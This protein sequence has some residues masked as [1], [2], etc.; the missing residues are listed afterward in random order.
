MTEREE[1]VVKRNMDFLN[2]FSPESGQRVLEYLSKVLYEKIPTY[3]DNNP[4]GTAF[5]EG[6]RFA[7]LEIRHWLDMDI[8]K[9]FK[10][11]KDE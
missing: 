6:K 7:I 4:M 8:S 1:L 2:T 10:E 9:L 5:N 3:V 11:Q